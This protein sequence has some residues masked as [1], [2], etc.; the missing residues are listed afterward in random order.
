MQRTLTSS[1]A[2]F[3]QSWD[4]LRADKHLVVFPILSTVATLAVL[5]SFAVP[6]AL[7]VPWKE[8]EF[9]KLTHTPW[10]YV[11]LF[12]FY[13]INFFIVTFFNSALVACASNRFAGGDSS[14]AAGLQQAAA[15][16]PQ[17]LMWT[18]VA[19]TV[20]MVLRAIQ[21]RAGFIG[22]IVI[23]LIGM[24]WAIATYFVV[25][26]LVIE[27]VGPVEAI[28]RSVAV[29]RKNWGESLVLHLGL[30]L[31]G[32]LLWLVAFTPA[33]IGGGVSIATST[34]VPLVVGGALSVVLMILL[35]LVTSTLRVIVQTALYRFATTGEAPVGFDRALLEGA[36]RRK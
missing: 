5:A 35:A 11:G 31:V 16:L 3:R 13:F 24:G 4:V 26:V 36:I 22:S 17:I 10:W 6:V 33:M 20:G 2:L 23:R 1:W 27:G 12:V 30:G 32:F 14:A 19:A 18:A 28:K 21:E 15:R 34:V 7:L 29:L 8:V 9:E 25:P